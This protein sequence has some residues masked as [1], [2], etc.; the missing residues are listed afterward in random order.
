MIFPDAREH[1]R[2]PLIL[3]P[4]PHCAKIVV[5][6][7]LQTSHLK[8]GFLVSVSSPEK[9]ESRISRIPGS[10]LSGMSYLPGEGFAAIDALDQSVNSSLATFANVLHMTFVS[11]ILTL[12]DVYRVG[13]R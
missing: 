3:H 6:L 10:L 1:G 11:V 2:H 7:L 12:F 13:L 8:A 9:K 5:S 4:H